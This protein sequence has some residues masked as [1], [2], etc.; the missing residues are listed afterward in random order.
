MNAAQRW[1]L[2]YVAAIATPLHAQDAVDFNR[3]IQP[4]LS[5]ACFQCHGP[6]KN[7]REA[8]LRF[9]QR[10][11]LFSKRDGR[12]VVA[13]GKTGASLLI[14]RIITEDP[15]LRMPPRDSGKEL[16]SQ[17]IELLKRWVSEGA[18]WERHWS[19]IAPRQRDL[20]SVQDSSSV[21]NGIDNFVARKLEKLGLK[22]SV[23]ADKAALLRRVTFDLTG[24]PPTLEEIDTFLADKSDDAYEKVVDRLLKSSAY[25][26]RM[27][28]RWLDAAR[29]A[30]TSGYQND[31][32]RYMWRWR[33]WVINAYNSNMPFDQFT[34]EQLAG[35]MLPDATLDQ[36]IASGFNRNH[37]GNA[38]G[39]II[40]EEYHVEY[41]VDRVDTTATVWLGLTMGC[42]RCHDHKFDPITQKEFY[43]VFAYF[44]NVPE[45]GRAIKEG[46]SP[47][48]IKAPTPKQSTRLAELTGA[49]KSVRQTFHDSRNEIATAQT[50]W[51]KK[52]AKDSN[53]EWTPDAGLVSRFALNGTATDSGNKESQSKLEGHSKFQAGVFGKAATFDGSSYVKAGTHG[54]FTYFDPFSISVWIR[55]TKP[56][57]TIVSRMKMEPRGRGYYLH[58]EDGRLQ[59]NL[60]VR[61]LDDSL[62]VET[63]E[64]VKLNEWTHIAMTYDGS[65]VPG[66]VKIYING[67]AVELKVNQ[68]FINQTFSQADLPIRVGAGHSNFTGDIDE[69]RIYE[70]PL[71][72]K[73]ALIL[74]SSQSISEIVSTEA[75]KRSAADQ[76]KIREYF[77]RIAAGEK[78]RGIYEAY[79]SA[80]RER[81]QFDD[82]LPTVMVMQ[83]MNQPRATFVL[84][85]GEYDK[86]G[87]RVA[88]GVPASLP[89]LPQNVSNNRLGFAR[90]LV[91]PSNPLTARV[92]V[93]RYWQMYFGHGLVRTAEDFGSQG[94]RPTHPEL[95]D[96]LAR[97]FVKSGWDVKAMQ[98]LIVMS[99]TYRQSSRVT[100]S[101][102]ERD[103]DNRL[104]ARGPRIRL[105]AEMIR[106]QALVASGLYFEKIGGASVR[107]YQPAGLWKEIATVADYDQS[108]GRDL[109]RRSLYTYWKR[110]VS[111]PS[112][113]TFDASTRET[114]VVKPTRTNTP[115]QALNLMND[116]TYVEAARVLAERVMKSDAKTPM[117]R[118][119]RA[120]RLVTSR[121]PSDREAVILTKGFNY[122]REQFTKDVNA[123]REFVAMGE[124]KADENLDVVELA[125]YATMTNLILNL[126]ETI[127]KQ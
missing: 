112:M 41:V 68:D 67:D 2:I 103:P 105:S 39:G 60:V 47:P 106:D 73:D 94:E 33:D 25:G 50:A 102:N 121:K 57:G 12:A 116:V 76:A 86:H 88:T 34:V 29:Y 14:D 48:F 93:N 54:D 61:W 90:W 87:E 40:A 38:E 16:T 62:R 17:Q 64:R 124:Q 120:F 23:E 109:Y 101:L 46:N 30:D 65:R 9:D 53:V 35:D 10:D 51:E 89:K 107:P 32:P 8:D 99:G 96:W 28:V 5:D 98:K 104:L 108:H 100:D 26:E 74:S 22:Q 85:R 1:I 82:A 58:L 83:E 77:L 4:I 66:G 42:A 125:A 6:D 92:A 31:G 21:R 59:A 72:A 117:A 11:G 55:P 97:Q 126:D 122:Q 3:D 127:T 36:R 19:L 75:A 118:L 43:Q 15:D 119:T 115:L 71:T 80:R 45:F 18:K 20:P 44:N 24:L 49:L 113:M 114:C 52:L 27:A 111:P 69:S 84:K 63:T 7:N 79:R 123:A 91:D 37:R 95:L 81:K 78:I 56:S 110:T 13:P 70:R